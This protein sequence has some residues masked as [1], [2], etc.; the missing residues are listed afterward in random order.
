MLQ[1]GVV[2]DSTAD[3]PDGIFEK[4]GVKVVSLTVRFGTEEFLDKTE[5]TIQQFYQ[6]LPTCTEV[7]HPATSQPSPEAFLAAF[8]E[9]GTDQ[10][11]CINIAENLS[12]TTQSAKRPQERLPTHDI[13]VVDSQT[14]SLGLGFLVEEAANMAAQGKTLDEIEREILEMVPKVR[15]FAMLDTLKY[16]EKGGRIG[17]ASYWVGA[18]LNFKPIIKVQRGE[19]IPVSRPRTRP[20]GIDELIRTFAAEGRMR[21]VGVIHAADQEEALNVADT[22]SRYY[23]S[24]IPVAE[25]GPVLGTHA[26]PG[27]IGICGILK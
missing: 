11:I 18:L 15:V 16:L 25:L 6:K 20:K 26:G 7:T 2:T 23:P 21:R 5:L 13:R 24:E 9:L 27:A 19:V 3:A 1:V 8:E 10:I 14:T 22:L 12:G 4:L 17:K